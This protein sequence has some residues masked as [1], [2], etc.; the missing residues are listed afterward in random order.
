M[1]DQST[2]TYVIVLG[3]LDFD[4]SQLPGNDRPGNK[5]RELTA[6]LHGRIITRTDYSDWI[7]RP[8]TLNVQCVSA[9][10]GSVPVGEDM[11]M[12]L[13]QSGAGY[14]LDV[15]PCGG[16]VFLRPDHNLIALARNCLAGGPCEPR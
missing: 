14:T 8:I 6:K 2:D 3:E 11:L 5:G 1:A 15:G 9:W 4:V 12:F 10:C 16:Y 7:D 13:R